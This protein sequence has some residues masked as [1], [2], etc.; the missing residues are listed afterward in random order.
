MSSEMSPLP[1][2]DRPKGVPPVVVPLTGKYIAQLFLVP[3]IIVTIVLLLLLAFN[4]LTGSAHTPEE[5]LKSLDN[6]NADIRWRAASDLAQVL[7]RDD[8]LAADPRFALEL[9]ERL[10]KAQD[11]YDREE[12]DL[13]Q[14]R[15]QMTEQDRKK[16][17]AT[18]KAKRDY[19]LFLGSCLGNMSVPV[20]ATLLAEVAE[21]GKGGEEKT[22]ALFRRRA[23]WSLAN[24]GENLKRFQKLPPE[25]QQKTLAGLQQEVSSAS[26]DRKTWAETA[27]RYLRDGQS[28]GVIRPLV[29]CARD[30]DPFLRKLVA[31]ALGF[32][33]GDAAENALA[34]TTLLQLSRDDGHGQT[35][36]IEEGD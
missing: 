25:E 2:N 13:G 8:R 14:R 15:P 22:T 20:G 26:G 33:E 11:D 6:T 35:I 18:L 16:A 17:E 23:V 9:A 19:A 36:K 30:D 4:W 27:L 24:L 32:W 28:L 7:L 3:G 1:A 10:R 29:A 12:R 21:K 34:E 5:F 31:L